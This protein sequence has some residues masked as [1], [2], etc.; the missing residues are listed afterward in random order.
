MG[1]DASMEVGSTLTVNADNESTRYKEKIKNK[2]IDTSLPL[3]AFHPGLKGIDT[4]TSATEGYFA[5]KGLMYTHRNG[6]HL[7]LTHLHVKE[8]I[9]CIRNG[10]K[11]SCGID[12]GF[13]EG[14]TCHMATKSFLEG[15]KVEWDSVKRKII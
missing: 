12:R 3:F 15:R 8:W 7:D 14:I 11:P 6:K 2:I 4:I 1:H 13:Q 5:T 10:K 9:D